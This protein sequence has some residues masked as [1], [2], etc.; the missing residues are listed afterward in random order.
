MT[1]FTDEIPDEAEELTDRA[2]EVLNAGDLEGAE[3]LA[4]RLRDLS[5]SSYFEIQALV[6]LDRE[7][8]ELA[9]EVL[10]QGVEEAPFV[11]RLWQLLGNTLSDAGDF[12]DAM[13]CY[14]SALQFDLDAE[15]TASLQFNRATLLSRI[16]HN[17]EA[18]ALLNESGD[19]IMS[20]PLGL[21]WRAEALRLSILADLGQR[22]EVIERAD[23]LESLLSQATEDSVE[24]LAVVLI[25]GGF[26][27]LTCGENL[28]AHK[29][30][31][32]ALYWERTNGDALQLLRQSDVTAP[33]AARYF[34]V[35]LEGDWNDEAE[36][37][38]LSFIKTFMV[39]ARGVEEAEILALEMESSHWETTLVRVMESEDCGECDE[40]SAGVYEA[41]PYHLYPRSQRDEVEEI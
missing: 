22:T 39:V 3:I 17:D 26:A 8:P 36:S 11:W 37:E 23:A 38:E 10:K 7:E 40:T 27:L 12:E 35:V 33:I 1:E 15:D 14:E 16:G 4:S 31:Q 28:R 13:R 5:Y 25:Q 29:W 6:H 19:L 2:F 32:R 30:A 24:S 20:A 21:Q 9:L 18:L 41:S 34:Q